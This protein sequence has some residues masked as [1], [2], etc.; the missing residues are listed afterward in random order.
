[1][2]DDRVEAKRYLWSSLRS[3]QLIGAKKILFKKITLETVLE[4]FAHPQVVG[5]DEPVHRACDDLMFSEYH[6]G[7]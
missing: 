2:V 5:S 3:M 4:E 7:H 6:L 1:M